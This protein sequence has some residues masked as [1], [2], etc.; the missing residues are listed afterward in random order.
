[1]QKDVKMALG[2]LLSIANNKGL[3]DVTFTK[4]LKVVDQA[5]GE[6]LANN[7]YDGAYLDLVTEYLF[8][9]G[10]GNHQNISLAEY[11]GI[12]NKAIDIS[13]KNLNLWRWASSFMVPSTERNYES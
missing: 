6:S 9:V 12:V 7:D 8:A 3:S 10:E 2:N 13:D 1:M 5:L 11:Q 4:Y